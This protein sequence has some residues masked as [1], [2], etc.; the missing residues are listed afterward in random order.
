MQ[1]AIMQPYFFPYIGYFQLMNWAETFVILDDVQYIQ[2]GWINR[3]TILVPQGKIYITI[4]TKKDLNIKINETEI[5]NNTNWREKI[6]KSL[7]LSYKRAPN[8]DDV[9]P[10]LERVIIQ[11]YTFISEIAF[12]SIKCVAEYLSLDTKFILSSS[13]KKESFDRIGRINEI[14]N[15]TGSSKFV[16][17]PGSVTLYNKLDFIVPSFYLIPDKEISYKQ[18]SNS[19]EP[20][21]SIIDIMMFNDKVQI[22]K[23]LGM[24]TLI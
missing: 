3:N 23:M 4:A 7:Y 14:L 5:L 17:P 6:L 22:C 18:F 13:L 8:F 21:L 24:Y 12:E 1:T 15:L 19:F 11:R 2:R 20:N 9:Y 16:L 10:L